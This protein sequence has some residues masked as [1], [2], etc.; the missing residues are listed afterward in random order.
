[1]LQAVCSPSWGLPM[2]PRKRLTNEFVKNF[3]TGSEND[4]VVYLRDFS[5]RE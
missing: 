5:T 3:Q 2:P 4:L 1:M